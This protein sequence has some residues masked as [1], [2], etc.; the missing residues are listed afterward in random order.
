[1][2]AFRMVGLTVLGLSCAMTA[3]CEE[4]P[5]PIRV[6]GKIVDAETGL[7][8][9][10]FV[11]QGGRYDPKKGPQEFT[12]GYSESRRTSSSGRFS[13][14]LR[15]HDGWTARILADGYY[16]QP[17]LTA[18]P[19]DGK[20]QIEITLRMR[21]GRLI[22]GRVLDH[23][24]QPKV[25]ASVYSVGKRGKYFADGKAVKSHDGGEDQTA[26]Y[27]KTDEEGRFE[28]RIGEVKSLVVASPELHAWPAPIPEGDQEVQIRLPK[29]ARLVLWYD[30]EGAEP[31][32]KFFWQFLSHEMKGFEGIRI[33]REA[34]TKQREALVISGLPAGKYQLVRSRM[35]HLKHIGVGQFLDR[36]WLELQPGER[37]VV[38]FLRPEGMRVAGLVKGLQ[39]AGVSKA[40]VSV[41]P[42]P[43][44]E[45]PGGRFGGWI[46]LDARL[47]D[48][49]GKFQTERLPPGTYKITA[50]GYLPP[51]PQQ[52]FLSGIVGPNFTAEAKVTV[53]EKGE[54][55]KVELEFKKN[56]Q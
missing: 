52:R 51:D 43:E 6:T 3:W 26:R 2:P 25:G 20:Q 54:A 55:P 21:P 19:A 30:I 50:H 11:Q 15:W 56:G 1:M 37:K 31:K 4:K 9:T 32:E 24:G 7:P 40:M 16:P 48:E 5:K 39:A 14:T 49:Q 10:R 18:A 17:I 28:M 45:N 33:E 44:P 41:T 27:V 12:W 29:P 38:R 8:I 35:L 22:R 47:T 42:D 36:R 13:A 34:E 23:D 46:K 53:P